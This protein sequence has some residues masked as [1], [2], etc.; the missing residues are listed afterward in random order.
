MRGQFTATEKSTK[1]WVV[2]DEESLQ[3]ANENESKCETTI[4]TFNTKPAKFHTEKQAN[5]WASQRLNM[6]VA[7]KVCFNHRWLNHKVDESFIGKQDLR[8]L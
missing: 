8:V 1:L 4:D 6:W 3:I 2:L 7:V 5:A